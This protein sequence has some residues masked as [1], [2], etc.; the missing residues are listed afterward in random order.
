MNRAILACAG[1]L[2][3]ATAGLGALT[4]TSPA[5]AQVF[6]QAPYVPAP[7]PAVERLTSRV[8]ALEAELRRA[9]GRNEQLMFDLGNARRTAEEANS[10]RLRAER[11]IEALQL[12]VDALERL[13]RGEPVDV[14]SLASRP[15]EATVNLTGPAGAADP[16]LASRPAD[17]GTA[18]QVALPED[19]AELMKEARNMLLAGDY[20]AAQNAFSLYLTR[21]GKGASAS[22][23]QYLLGEA[24]LYQGSYPEAAEA[25]GE[26][27]SEYPDAARGPEGL[28]KLARAMRLMD[29]KSEACKALGLMPTRFPRASNAAKTLAA[30]EKSRAGC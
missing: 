4:W 25:Y 14:G 21:H 1:L 13:A 18:A 28:V 20:P 22:E 26:L 17:A 16:A 2:V 19:E 5:S 3:A 29:K 15:A 23:A 27:L 10:G 12:R 24:L 11:E 8:D 30:T 6:G 9:T 7:D